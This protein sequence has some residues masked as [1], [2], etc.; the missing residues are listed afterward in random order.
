MIRNI[1]TQLVR[2]TAVTLRYDF[3]ADDDLNG[4]TA[5]WALAR[6]R[7][8]DRFGPAADLEKAGVIVAQ[9]CSVSLIGADTA[10]LALGAY[11]YELEL[12]DGAGEGAVAA[13]GR[14]ILTAEIVNT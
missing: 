9:S 13:Q 11:Q 5:R 12:V 2:G 8:D 10:N 7:S 14:L 3:P 1:A 6:I 4:L